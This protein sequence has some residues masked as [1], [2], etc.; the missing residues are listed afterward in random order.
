[1]NPL[2]KCLRIIFMLGAAFE[3]NIMAQGPLAPPGPPAPTMRTL[4]QVEPRTPISSIPF[5]I[6]Q[7]G[8]YYLTSNL[9]GPGHVG[10][11]IIIQTN[12][13]T[14]DLMGFALIGGTGTGVVVTGIGENRFHLRNGSILNWGGDGIHALNSE[15]AIYEQLTLVGNGGSGL[16]AGLGA[17]VTACA[18]IS[19]QQYGLFVNSGVVRDCVAR[20]NQGVGIYLFSGII[21]HC[22]AEL[23]ESHGLV[24]SRGVLVSDCVANDN[25]GDG[26]R[27]GLK[28][29]AVRNVATGNGTGPGMA[30]ITAMFGGNRIEDNHCS[31]NNEAGIISDLGGGNDFIFRNTCVNNAG[32]EYRVPGLPG[33]PPADFNVFG[34]VLTDATNAAANAW[35]NFFRE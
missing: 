27:L 10:N 19:N 8:S 5:I 25:K 21:Q 32:F 6:T 35:A 22:A 29:Q 16:R 23:N 9:G 11:G 18:A 1:M 24:A 34:P 14:I 33:Q 26:I 31:E 17:R 12:Q 2:M 13:V 30:G 3:V 20:R 7:P 15:G 4:S 28:C